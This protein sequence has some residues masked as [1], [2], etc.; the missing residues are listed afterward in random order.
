[1]F[2]RNRDVIFGFLVWCGLVA[3]ALTTASLFGGC[4]MIQ[5]LQSDV[6]SLT[7]PA[8]SD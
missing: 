6:H 1:M 5:G 4:A 3:L 7:A 8:D 2:K